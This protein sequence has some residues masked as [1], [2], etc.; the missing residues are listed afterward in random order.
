MMEHLSETITYKGQFPLQAK[1]LEPG[2]TVDLLAS[3]YEQSNMTLLRMWWLLEEHRTEVEESSELTQDIFRLETKLDLMLAMVAEMAKSHEHLP[4][5]TDIHISSTHIHW[6]SEN[7]SGFTVGEPL[8][9]ECYVIPGYPIPLRLLG[10]LSAVTP[11]DGDLWL[12]MALSSLSE[13]ASDSLEKI[14]FRYHRRAIATSR[15]RD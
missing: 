5:E 3:Q 4:A 9:V 15:R 12:S 6:R 13:Q 10:E 14:L 11:L 8:L 1:A 2:Q 7:K